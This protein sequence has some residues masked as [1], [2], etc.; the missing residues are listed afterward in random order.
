M[1]NMLK[2]ININEFKSLIYLKFKLLLINK[3]YLL[4]KF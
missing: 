2:K 3:L 4:F 1:K